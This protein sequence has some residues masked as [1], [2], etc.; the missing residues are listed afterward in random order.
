MT[1]IPVVLVCVLA[2][3]TLAAATVVA[4]SV[5]GKNLAQYKAMDAPLPEDPP[6]PSY[7]SMYQAA[8]AGTTLL[9]WWQ[10]D[11]LLGQPDEQG[12]TRHDLTA[13]PD[14]TWHVDGSAGGG[15]GCCP[16][17]PINGLK[18]MW[19]GACASG[20]PP[21]CGYRTLP[22]YGNSWDQRLLSQVLACTTLTVGYTVVWDS[23][24]AYDFTYVEYWDDAQQ[25][26]V[27]FPVDGGQ[28]WYD[29]SGGPLVESFLIT[30]PNAT[31]QVRFRFVSDG[32]WSDQDGLWPTNEG[33]V[34]IDDVT[35]SCPD[36]GA[37]FSYFENWEGELCGAKGSNDGMWGAT[38]VA[39]YGTYADLHSGASMLQTD[40]CA[41]LI[42]SLWAFID[43]PAKTNYAC[44][45][46]PL[47]GAVPFGPDANGLYL[48]NEVWSP[49]VPYAGTGDKVIFSFYVYRDLPLDN[50]V[51]YTWHVRGWLDGCPLSWEDYSFVYYG[52]GKDWL[53]ATFD[54]GS[55]ILPGAT[56]IQACVGAMDM[57]LY[58]CGVYGTG[59][60][61]SHAPLFDQVRLVRVDVQGPQW[62]VRHIDLFQDNFSE[63][64]T[65]TGPARADM[66]QDILPSANPGILPGDS[67]VVGVNDPNGLGTDGTV[68]GPAVYCFVRVGTNGPPPSPAKRGAVIQS[69]D[70][71][72]ANAPSPG[73]VR[74]PWIGDLSCGGNLWSQYRMD[75]TYTSGGGWVS[76]RYCFD[77]E[78]VAN[79]YHVNEDQIANIGVFTPGDTIWYFFGAQNTLGQWSYWHRT[80]KGQG[81]SRSTD[82]FAEA[83][84][85]PCEFSILPDAGRLPGDEGDILYVDDADDRGGPAQLYFDTAFDW[86]Q[87]RHRV[88]RF[89][90][91]GP[92]SV[93]GNSLA[94]RVQDVF[95]QIIGDPIEIY[96]KIIWCSSNLSSGLIGDGGWENGGSGA[97]KS[98]DFSLLHTFL[99]NHPGDPGVYATGDDIAQEWSTL[100]GAGALAVKGTYMNFTLV[101]GDHKAVGEPVSPTISKSL[102]SPIGP[103]SMI[104]YGGC[105]LL[106]DFD[107]IAP[108]GGS[109]RAMQYTLPGNGAVLAQATP[110][111][112]QTVARFV[113]EGFAYNYIR[114]DDTI[115]PQV[116]LDR[117][118][119]LR[120]ILVW[121]ENLIPDPIGVDPV[122]FENRLDNA[123]PNP[124]NPAT[125]I[126][127]SIKDRGHVSLRIYNAAGQLIRTLVD[128]MQSPCETGFAETWNGMNDQ[129]QPVSSG[130]YFYKLVTKGF[131]QTKKMVL[132]K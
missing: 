95:V 118:V 36:A 51:F 119:H 56:E 108:V 5:P 45:G 29:G 76:E 126:K 64:G 57:C 48:Q 28:N 105:P 131:T 50:L 55:L 12:W 74:Y 125:T 65:I 62:N 24:P 101:N 27:P 68:G 10:F 58:W 16:I 67:I 124:F 89:D 117:A 120:D 13:Y 63:D 75:N 49:V 46:Y 2:A 71:R 47:Q 112:A 90:V 59:S 106:N 9:G 37:E 111:V 14:T 21:Y 93:V 25:I 88:D 132:L 79:G 122:A 96:R 44:G 94:S 110:T 54:V 34:K 33:A 123:Y 113:L 39:S 128:E 31:T 38:P 22:G 99:S 92:S 4:K 26:W 41:R 20:A 84:A 109:F 104:A 87:I 70:V 35:L 17:S 127:Y 19:C 53:N 15:P 100:I 32:A 78:D 107:V 40:P 102:G 81:A 129:G 114:D 80:L 116:A 23:E 11:N 3:L 83:C 103:S 97:E 18:S 1:R 85:D 52:G 60:C 43:D 66:A 8:A 98:D 121:Y 77:L 130:V 73:A 42:S 30:P 82:V 115:P 69:P 72:P 86:L 91:M 7:H 61:H 6:D